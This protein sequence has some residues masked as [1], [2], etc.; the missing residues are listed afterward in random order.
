M[1]YFTKSFENIEIFSKKI[2]DKKMPILREKMYCMFAF[3]VLNIVVKIIIF[4][5]NHIHY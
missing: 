3:Q 4:K 2:A 1:E 5:N